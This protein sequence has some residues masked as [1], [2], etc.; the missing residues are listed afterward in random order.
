MNIGNND[1][2]MYVTRKVINTQPL[3]NDSVEE[4]ANAPIN[5]D[6]FTIVGENNNSNANTNLQQNSYLP[7]EKP[8]SKDDISFVES[9][10]RRKYFDPNHYN[11]RDMLEDVEEEIIEKKHREDADFFNK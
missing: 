6:V 7:K 8:K 5:K 10:L 4:K 9:A 11:Y 3:S 2:S 1:T